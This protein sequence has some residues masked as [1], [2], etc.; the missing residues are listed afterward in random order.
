MK[1]PGSLGGNRVRCWRK[2]WG[3]AIPGRKQKGRQEG[4]AGAAGPELLSPP[5]REA[6][7]AL[8]E[9]SPLRTVRKTP[10]PVR[11]GV[12]SCLGI[13]VCFLVSGQAGLGDIGVRRVYL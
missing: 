12:P 7:R 2:Q 9:G 4:C 1:R 5:G 3:A 6:L 10:C 13:G 8:Q 11:P